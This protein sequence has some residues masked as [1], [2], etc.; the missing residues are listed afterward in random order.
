MNLRD[1]SWSGDA[2]FCD[3]N[4][5]RFPDLYVVNMQGADHYYENDGGQ[6]FVDRT[7]ENFPTTPW[8]AMGVKFFDYNNDGLM[9]LYVVDMHSDMTDE[10]RLKALKL[11]LPVE[12]GKS[13]AFCGPAYGSILQSALTNYIFG[14]AFYENQ[15]AEKFKERSDAI[16][17][18]TYWPWGISV[19]D[20][21]AD[22]YEDVFVSA[23]MGFPFRYGINSVLLND[24]GRTFFDAE[25]VLGVEPRLGG[26]IEIDY[27]TLD[28]DGADKGHRL[29]GGKP[30]KVVVRG[31]TST[32]SSVVFDLDDDGDLDIVTN[33]FNDRSQ[34]LFSNLT[35]R[36]KI[37]FIKV[38]LVGTVSN[39]D[40]LGATVKVHAEDRVY[41]R[42]HDGKSGY[43]AQSSLPLYFGLGK[44][45][46]IDRVV[47]HWPSGTRQVVKEN[48]TV[49]ALLQVVETRP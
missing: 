14:N 24:N 9:D 33:E 17:L 49:N 23:G 42:Y 43:L 41:T 11:E 29:C 36:R 5:D 48:I 13:E 32:R 8:G 19:G 16:G 30:G 27:L 15:G 45:T 39:R 46:S 26:R 10:Q 31:P 6:R 1:D 47:V 34:V 37:Q 2:T 4:H 38:K 12:K 7:K 22:G 18:E 44:A 40:G 21:N 25:F 3:L 20:L 35:S 28:C